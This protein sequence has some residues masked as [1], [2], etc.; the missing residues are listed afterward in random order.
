MVSIANSHPIASRP[1]RANRLN[2]WFPGLKPWAEPSSPTNRTR[3]P[4]LSS[5]PRVRRD[6]L[7]TSRRAVPACYR[8]DEIPKQPSSPFGAEFPRCESSPNVQLTPG[9]KAGR[10]TYFPGEMGGGWRHRQ[11]NAGSTGSG[12][13]SPYQIVLNNHL[14]SKTTIP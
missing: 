2:G 8:R 1:F 14:K 4:S 6:A 12:G 3:S 13:A 11:G 9:G 5:S 10:F 7:L